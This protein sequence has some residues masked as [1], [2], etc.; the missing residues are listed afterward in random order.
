[1]ATVPPQGLR[2]HVQALRRPCDRR[3]PRGKGL[4]K[5]KP[6]ESAPRPTDSTAAMSSTGTRAV[7][8][9][10]SAVSCAPACALR[11]ASMCGAD[12]NLDAPTSP[13]SAS[14][15]STRSTT[16]A[17]STATVRRGMPHAGHHRV[18]AVRVLIHQSQRCDL[19]QE[20]TARR[21]RRQA[22]QLPWEDW[23]D[24]E[25]TMTLADAPPRPGR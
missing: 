9:S 12:N 22:R 13:G 16:C 14:A 7:W 20:R 15:T 18:E 10:A 24:G 11:S 5:G 17:A 23:S 25:D 8:R 2:R 3:L 4:E 21:R 6:D 1:M 19:H